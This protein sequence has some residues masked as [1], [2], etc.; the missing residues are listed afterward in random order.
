MKALVHPGEFIYIYEDDKRLRSPSV[1]FLVIIQAVY[2]SAIIV[3]E[4]DSQNGLASII[5]RLSL[6]EKIVYFYQYVD[7]N[8]KLIS[9]DIVKLE[10]KDRVLINSPSFIQS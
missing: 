3:P 1:P 4:R 7:K 6:A 8:Q 2:P 10:N 5:T 9:R